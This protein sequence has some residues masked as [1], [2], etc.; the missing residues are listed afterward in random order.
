M[1]ETR[2]SIP[3]ERMQRNYE[4]VRARIA[5]AATKV[6][7]PIDAVKLVAVTKSVGVA[8][9]KCLLELGLRNLG[10]ARVQDGERKIRGVLALGREPVPRQLESGVLPPLR[11]HLIGHLQTNKA[12]KAAKL[13]QV[14]HSVDS[15]RVAQA[16]NKERLKLPV[17]PPLPCLLEI[18]AAGE[19]QK[20][21]LAPDAAAVG[22]LLQQCAGLPGLQLIGLMCMAPYSENPEA[23]SRPV[24][25]K[26]RELRDALN[27][28]NC[29]P[30]PL[31][32][33]SMGMTQDYA[34]AVEEGATMV[35]VGTALFE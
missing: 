29:Y 5:D 6:S 32:E 31:T 10:E 2:D 22:E 21:G 19:T 14:V 28:G 24:F 3:P 7:R 13:F 17:L 12:D 23:T 25:R 11:W 33:L 9:I 8:E 26:V 35:R 4:E 34:I 1:D 16:L 18:N 27:A 30:S 15:L 20:F